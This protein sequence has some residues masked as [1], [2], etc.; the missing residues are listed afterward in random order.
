MVALPGGIVR[1]LHGLA[2]PDGLTGNRRAAVRLEGDR[3]VGGNDDG[4]VLTGGLIFP[5]SVFGGDQIV[6]IR[7]LGHA[8]RGDHLQ[9]EGANQALGFPRFAAGQ[10]HEVHVKF[11]VIVPQADIRGGNSVAQQGAALHQLE[12]IAVVAD[13]VLHTV[14]GV[15]VRAVGSVQVKVHLNDIPGLNLLL[16]TAVHGQ[17]EEKVPG[18]VRRQSR[19]NTGQEKHH[20]E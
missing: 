9:L 20:G 1:P 15:G 18:V 10:G 5:G 19:G 4:H 17:L 14:H 8:G 3:A 12:E 2:V 11:P 6:L 7:D 16:V 13:F